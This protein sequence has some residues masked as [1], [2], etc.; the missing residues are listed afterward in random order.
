[1][2]LPREYIIQ[3]FYE[4]AGSPTFKKYTN[5]YNACCP[6]CREG[7]SWGKKKRLYYMVDD[8]YMFCQNCQR[9]WNPINW[10]MEMSGM[11]FVEVM[12]DSEE[13]DSTEIVEAKKEPVISKPSSG[14]L[15]DDSINLFDEQQVSYYKGNK[16]VDD[17]LNLIKKRRLDTA[18]NHPRGLF[19]SL[20]DF[21]HKNRL[22][23]PFYDAENQIQFYQTRSMYGE[24][25]KYLSKP[26]A[27]KTVFG[28]RNIDPELDYLFIFEGPIDSMFVKNGVAMGS[29]SLS[30]AQEDELEK[31]RLLER[32][33][34]LDNQLNNEDVKKKVTQLIERGEKVFFWPKKYKDFKDLNEICVKCKL[35]KVKPEFFINNA[36]SGMEALIKLT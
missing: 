28:I 20:K 26:G 6:A 29:I 27:D 4:F 24:D 14:T 21:V 1:M 18:I 10:V 25:P 7:K 23:I 35:D 5:T 3:K 30:D 36:F 15:P 17:A 16:V 31:Y 11:E 34:V 22:I 19:V 12:R 8:D 32:I 2:R 33:W 13:Y 9:N